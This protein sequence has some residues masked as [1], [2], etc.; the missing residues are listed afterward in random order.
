MSARYQAKLV[1]N[2]LF[3]SH[4]TR[5]GHGWRFAQSSPNMGKEFSCYFLVDCNVLVCR[6]ERL[7][8][9][10]IVAL[11][12]MFPQLC[13]SGWELVHFASTTKKSLSKPWCNGLK[14]HHH[15]HDPPHQRSFHIHHMLIYYIPPPRK[16]CKKALMQAHLWHQDS[17]NS[18][19]RNNEGGD[20]SSDN[21]GRN[22][23]GSDVRVWGTYRTVGPCNRMV[24]EYRG[25][26]KYRWLETIKQHSSSLENT[27]M[28]AVT[29]WIC[30]ICSTWAASLR[31]LGGS[32]GSDS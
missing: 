8:S 11:W 24:M 9:L 7:L 16:R 17:G 1:D 21:G 31:L 22:S 10:F 32:T 6:A 26:V 20:A 19:Q 15:L 14:C 12:T 27:W 23:S 18:Q 13:R 28:Q 4:C 25:N 5:H 2:G 30:P 29:T 3:R